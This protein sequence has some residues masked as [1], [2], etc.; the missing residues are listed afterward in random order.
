[1]G[2]GERFFEGAR[3]GNYRV[4]RELAR[5]GT[6]GHYEAEHVV[7]P[8]RALLKVLHPSP[9]NGRALAVQMLREACILEALR[10][11]GVPVVFESGVHDGRPWFAVECVAGAALLVESLAPLEVATIVRDAAVVLDH[12]HKRGVVH[13]SLRPER[14]LVTG[15]A[16]GFGVCIVDWADARTHDAA[17]AIPRMPTRGSRDFAAP[18]QVMHG[19]VDELA[20]VYALGA[21]A[22][23]AIAGTLPQDGAA[24]AI[25]DGVAPLVPL[26]VRCPL[27]PPELCAVIDLMLSRDRFDRPT[28]AQVATELAWVDTAMVHADAESDA[29]AAIAD[30]ELI[31]FEDIPVV[32]RI[33]RPRWTPEFVGLRRG[34]TDLDADEVE[35]E[36]ETQQSE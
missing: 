33:R 21:I 17:A 5:A 6:I 11:V 22:Y 4:V 8:R 10:H 23:R 28:A 7:L 29:M 25:A 24:S 18:E 13:A 2:T 32:P 34:D 1:M 27:A 12:A 19:L 36:L 35:M 30:I 16:R 31:D 20:D 3:V 15:R 9:S 26:E 14:I